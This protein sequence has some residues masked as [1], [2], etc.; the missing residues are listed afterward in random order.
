MKAKNKTE[1]KT[2][3]KTEPPIKNMIQL[4]LTM[5]A[6]L[7]KACKSLVAKFPLGRLK[8]AKVDGKIYYY[9]KRPSDKKYIS[10]KKSDRKLVALA[11]ALCKRKWLETMIRV[12][13]SNIRSEMRLQKKY[14][15]Y[16][17]SAIRGMVSD[18]YKFMDEKQW[19]KMLGS[20]DFSDKVLQSE[21]PAYREDLIHCTTFGLLVRSKSEQFI[22]EM[23][24]AAGIP[25]RYEPEI[26][27]TAPDG[28]IRSYYPDFLLIHPL[29]GNLY[30]EHIGKLGDEEYRKRNEP[31][32]LAYFHNHITPGI[33]LI[34]TCDDVG[35]AP[36]VPMFSEIIKWLSANQMHY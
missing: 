23:L 15:A 10:V 21:N 7:L 20:E 14:R 29:G 2:G 35:G 22:A 33:N 27:L 26:K 28:M 5:E 24:H 30:W 6:A 19:Y 18:A 36:S 11:W 3:P 9:L 12:L 16:D 17:F 32:Y 31:K 8:C 25:F 1:T 4:D 34:I 13:E